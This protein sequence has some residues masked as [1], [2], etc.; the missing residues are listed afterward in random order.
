MIV[1]MCLVFG[2]TFLPVNC[3]FLSAKNLQ[4]N[5]DLSKGI[6][7]F[8]YLLPTLL[9]SSSNEHEKETSCCNGDDCGLTQLLLLS[10]INARLEDYM[11]DKKEP[12]S[13]DCPAYDYLHFTSW[14]MDRGPTNYGKRQS[15]PIPDSCLGSKL[16][17]LVLSL[18]VSHNNLKKC[19]LELLSCM[20]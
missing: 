10:K 9:C 1:H 4:L 6:L 16:V 7:W 19:K 13:P 17:H 8:E 12:H 14:I 18:T 11:M 20:L 2:I 5:Y 15:W 3:S